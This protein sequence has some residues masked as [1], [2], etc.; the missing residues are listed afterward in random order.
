MARGAQ[1]V[2]QPS[3]GAQH[4]LL[5]KLGQQVDALTRGFS[6]AEGNAEAARQQLQLARQVCEALGVLAAAAA[7]SAHVWR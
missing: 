7:D 5:V 1:A 4:P 2:S 3:S 6:R